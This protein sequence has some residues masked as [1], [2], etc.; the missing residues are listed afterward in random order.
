MK[1]IIYLLLFSLTISCFREDKKETVI[2]SDLEITIAKD[3]TVL[4]L[5]K[6]GTIYLNDKKIGQIKENEIIDTNGTAVFY[7]ANDFIII[8]YKKDTIG[9]LSNKYIC[10]NDN[11]LGIFKWAKSGELER[12]HESLDV[13][14]YPNDTTLYR[15]A[16][17]ILQYEQYFKINL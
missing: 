9:D 17:L 5:D 8:D 11:F 6:K 12:N 1:N 15:T 16:S 7:I 14:I 13:K 10:I 4:K 3:S 2:I